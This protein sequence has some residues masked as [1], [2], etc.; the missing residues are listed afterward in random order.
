MSL[1]NRVSAIMLI[2]LCFTT[3]A[4]AQSGTNTTTTKEKTVEDIYLQ[5]SIEALIIK[6]AVQSTNVQTKEIGLQMIKQAIDNGKKSKEIHDAL[7]DLAFESTRVVVTEGG[8]GKPK[9]NYPLLRAKACEYLG[10]LG[11][12]EARVS[13]I[14]VLDSGEKEPIVLAATIY[15]LGMILKTENQEVTGKIARIFKGFNVTR[16]DDNLA[17]SVLLAYEKI[18]E[19]GA[20]FKDPDAIEAIRLIMEGSYNPVVIAKAQN[21]YYKKVLQSG[22]EASKK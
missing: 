20:P 12:D 2:C 22:K 5:D 11:T 18:M 21:L 17:M 6:D 9:N 4:F 19:S 15:S 10:Q 8:Y 16:P 1:Y 7:R 13:L 3:M 14:A